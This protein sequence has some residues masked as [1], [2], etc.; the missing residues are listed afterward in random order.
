MK[1]E[2]QDKK[3][4]LTLYLD[5]DKVVSAQCTNV[6]TRGVD[7][8]DFNIIQESDP[9]FFPRA[10]TLMLFKWEIKTDTADK[11]IFYTYDQRSHEKIETGIKFGGA[12]LNC[13]PAVAKIVK[14]SN[15]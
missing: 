4:D 6:Q 12:S 13:E 15:E 10:A 3:R 2:I 9:T 5:P 7:A 1:L 8:F 11:I 14:I